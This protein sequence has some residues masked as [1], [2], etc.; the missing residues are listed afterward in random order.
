MP[1]AKEQEITL[2]I[3]AMIGIT[4]KQRIEETLQR[5][6]PGS[7][8]QPARFAVWAKRFGSFMDEREHACT[9]Q[10]PDEEPEYRNVE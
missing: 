3:A 10:V 7:S 1:T 6:T 4:T 8:S 2:T 5:A 9:F